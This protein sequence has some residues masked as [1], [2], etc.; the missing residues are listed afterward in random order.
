MQWLSVRMV[1]FSLGVR[2]R[3]DSL[4]K[5]QTF[6]TMT[7]Q[8]YYLPWAWKYQFCKWRVAV[9]TPCVSTCWAE[10]TLG[11]LTS[12]D[13]LAWVTHMIASFLKKYELLRA[14]VSEWLWSRLVRS[15]RE[16]LQNRYK[17]MMLKSFFGVPIQTTGLWQ[18]TASIEVSLSRP[19]SSKSSNSWVGKTDSIWLKTCNQLKSL[20]DPIIAPLWLAV[21]NFLLL[22]QTW[23]DNSALKIQT[24]RVSLRLVQ[25]WQSLEF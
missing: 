24:F 3:M 11:A 23:A 10:L 5:V 15:I 7:F 6:Q 18:K 9:G 14:T 13:N 4:V 17:D 1:N 2:V 22:V 21:E 12:W 20:W 25:E 19:S 8:L 16:L